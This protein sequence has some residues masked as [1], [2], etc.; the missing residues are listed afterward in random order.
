M[1]LAFCEV[2]EAILE[3]RENEP[4]KEESEGLSDSDG[5]SEEHVPQGCKVD[6]P[7]AKMMTTVLISVCTDPDIASAT[8]PLL[9][10]TIR[11]L[12]RAYK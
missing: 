3:R 6:W 12:L 1:R 5:D 7:L 9:L 10:Y 11:L 8:M 4:Q 2:V